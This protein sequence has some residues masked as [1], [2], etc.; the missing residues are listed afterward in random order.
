M[1]GVS[2][3]WIILA[4]A[5]M[6]AALPD[7]AL[8]VERFPPP[9]FE[10]GYHLPSLTQPAGAWAA[11]DWLQ[12]GALAAG[13]GLATYLVLV[14]RSR[15]ALSWLSMA[16]LAYFGFYL[17]GCVCPIGSIQN[18][19]GGLAGTAY[20]ISLAV[21]LIFALPLAF[22]LLVGR[23][24]C[25][26]VCPLG[27]IQ[28]VVLLRPVRV[29]DWLAQGLGYVPYVYLGAATLF[30]ATDSR[31]LICEYDPFVSFFR[32]EGR[33]WMLLAGAGLLAIA[34]VVGRPYCRFLCP[35]GALLGLCARAAKWRVSISPDECVNCRL[36]EE[37][38]PFGAIRKPTLGEES[39]R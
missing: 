21:V 6:T 9:D 2:T 26:S 35:Y 32:M 28:D 23:V 31:Y 38:C 17:A 16:S 4:A 36:C 34:T 8:A 30:A 18:V 10:T 20:G 39:G 15:R 29:P 5:A 33:A 25:S 11:R 1:R 19:A 7:A 24:F 22:A 14:R 37:A 3:A 12:V 13:M 27:A